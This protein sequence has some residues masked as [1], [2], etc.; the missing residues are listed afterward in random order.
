MY[1]DEITIK[2]FRLLKNST[3]N[4]KDDICMMIGR[5]NSGKTSFLVLFEKFYKGVGFDYNDF[6]MSLRKHINSIDEETNVSQ[7]SIQL[8]LEI[9]YDST[10]DLCDLSEFILD[11]D[12][13]CNRVNILFEC[14]INKR[15]LLE[16]INSNKKISREKFI[17]KYISS[18][19][20]RK[21]YI[22]ES[23]NDLKPENK[24]KLIQ[25]DLDSV[26]K[27][28][29][30]EII[31]A[32]RSVSSSEEKTSKKVLSSLTTKYFNDNNINSPDK[33]ETINAIIA[34]MDNQLSETYKVFFKNFLKNSQEFLNLDEL[35]IISNLRASEIV[36]DSSE[37]IYGDSKEYL[38]EYLNG[39]GY[40]NILYLLLTIE[41]KKTV[42]N[43]NNKDIKLL[44]IEEPEAHTHPQLQY[45][46]ARK[47]DDLLKDINGLQTI[48]TTHSPHIVSNS[49]FENI[50]YL[51]RF[52]EEDGSENIIIKNFHNEL[53]LKYTEA[54]EFQF[55]KQYLSIE[56]AE[57][58]FAN[59]IIFIEGTSENMLMPYFISKFDEINIKLEEERVKNKQKE[60][61]EYK[62]LASQ[63]ISI[64]QVGA[65]AKVFR[66]FL[67]FL[68]IKTLVI[69]D[70][71]TTK[72]DISA[73]GR[74]SYPACAVNDSPVSTSN[75]TIKYYFNAPS[76]TE[77][78]SDYDEW[79]KKIINLDI[80]GVSNNVKVFYQK[81]EDGYHARSF[82]DSF[83]KKNYDLLRSNIENIRGL[84]CKDKLESE[85][86]VY[87]LTKAIIDKK[88]D[89]AASLLFLVHTDDSVEWKTP[90]YIKEGLEWIQK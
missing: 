51:L 71:D 64:L 40:M 54:T 81:E 90:S 12:P 23:K 50:R 15:K 70:I 25:K 65:N 57:L 47:I 37:V 29:D 7:L 52:E 78:R 89:F 18:F 49:Q 41:I 2:N 9:V 84:K 3:L 20:E 22:Y 74:K 83:I 45:I 5:N 55:I 35:K 30:F 32:K 46:F 60:E 39:L 21:I 79:F 68:D 59:K 42:F 87:E 82:E 27:L 36:N 67:E 28:I 56:A 85:T 44:F 33:F 58:F 86:D 10:D 1:I 19:L 17:K 80:Q 75:E 16:S 26:K 77:K 6:S 34:D 62:P 69:T 66:H 88:S 63:N 48:I 38:P 73:T 31:H 61:F 13:Q 11:L 8:R 53:S 4:F 24:D 76:F 72:L 43:R 14:S